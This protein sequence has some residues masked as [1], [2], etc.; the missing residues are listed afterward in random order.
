M[1]PIQLDPLYEAKKHEEQIYSLWLSQAAFHSEPN[2]D[3]TPFVVMMPPPNITGYL[4]MGH[5]LASTPG[6]TAIAVDRMN[7]FEALSLAGMAHPG[8]AAQS[9][10]ECDSKAQG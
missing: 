9:V 3:R 2:P 10:V 5:A 1:T 4:H 8:I 7:G 6:G